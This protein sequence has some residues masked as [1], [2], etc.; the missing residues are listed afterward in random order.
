VSVVTDVGKPTREHAELRREREHVVDVPPRSC[1]GRAGVDQ[2]FRLQPSE[3]N[4]DHFARD[5]PPLAVVEHERSRV[6]HAAEAV[7]VGLDRHLVEGETVMERATACP[8]S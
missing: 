5:D 2:S 4:E 6:N 7:R 1:I 3:R 8:A